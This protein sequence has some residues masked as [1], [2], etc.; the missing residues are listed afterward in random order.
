MTRPPEGQSSSGSSSHSR[1]CSSQASLRAA[2]VS[3]QFSAASLEG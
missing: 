3:R 2:A 1:S